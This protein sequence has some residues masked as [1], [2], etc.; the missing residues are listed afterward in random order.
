VGRLRTMLS[1]AKGV[2]TVSP[3]CRPDEDH[4]AR[5][6]PD[7][8]L[9]DCL[10][11]HPEQRPASLRRLGVCASSSES[12]C[13]VPVGAASDTSFSAWRSQRR[14]LAERP[15][16]RL[17][18]ISRASFTTH[19]ADPGARSYDGRGPALPAG[20]RRAARRPA[21]TQRGPPLR[22]STSI[23]APQRS[24]DRAQR[25]AVTAGVAPG[26]LIGWRANVPYQ[27]EAVVVL[28]T[29]RQVKR[30]LAAV[31]HDL[32]DVGPGTPEARRVDAGSLT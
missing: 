13:P 24:D 12:R 1:T 9:R 31:K 3:A 29:W 22:G 10:R 19:E 25:R 28:R 32:A 2:W 27:S 15:H 18:N 16:R 11:I 4:D 20:A 26:S 7:P 30:D 8:V 23:P 6:L 21:Y 5:F 17:A 14:V